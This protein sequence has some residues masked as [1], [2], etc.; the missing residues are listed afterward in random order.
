MDAVILLSWSRL[1][2]ARD[3]RR[4]SWLHQAKKVG[5][6]ENMEKAIKEYWDKIDWNIEYK[7][8]DILPEICPIC[9]KQVHINFYGTYHQSYV[10]HC[11]TPHCMTIKFRGL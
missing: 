4:L 2:K 6:E 5:Q 9:Q 10:I 8:D 7:D 11:E 3:K 1:S